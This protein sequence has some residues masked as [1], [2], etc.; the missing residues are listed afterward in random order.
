[1]IA[2]YKPKLEELS[3][4]QSLLADKETMSYNDKWGGTIDWPQEK[5]SVWAEK[6][7]KSDEKQF[8]YRYIRNTDNGEFVGEAAFRFDEDYGMHVISIIVEA[9]Q[10]G[11]G[12]GKAA[13]ELLIKHAKERSIPCLC[14]D[15]A[16]DNP[17]AALF[18]RRGF[19]EIWRTDEIIMLKLDLREE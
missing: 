5:W 16:A 18:V 1:M 7:L 8:F 12:Y 11:N 9:K 14:D 2:F 6:W 10:R 4:R 13:L 15:I 17:S 19:R 3:Y